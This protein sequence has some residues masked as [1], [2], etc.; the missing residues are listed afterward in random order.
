MILW[1]DQARSYS[2]WISTYARC[3]PPFWSLQREANRPFMHQEAVGSAN[4]IFI[5]LYRPE[6]FLGWATTMVWRS[7]WI[8]FLGCLVPCKILNHPKGFCRTAVIPRDEKN[9]KRPSGDVQKREGQ[10]RNGGN[11]ECSVGGAAHLQCDPE[12]TRPLGVS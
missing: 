9:R 5:K 6:F 8:S 2:T 12:T 11:P 1:K 7:T 4:V 3:M 10:R